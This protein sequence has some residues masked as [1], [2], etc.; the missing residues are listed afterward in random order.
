MSS[1]NN[2]FLNILGRVQ[3]AKRPRP[4]ESKLV[5]IIAVS[6]KQE[7][8]KMQDWINFCKDQGISAVF[9]ENYLQEYEKKAPVLSGDFETH[10]IGVL[11]SNKVRKSIELFEVIQTVHS[12]KLASLINTEALKQN[13]QQ[14]IFLQVN[15]SEDSKKSGFLIPDLICFIEDRLNNYHSI[16]L[17]GLMTITEFYSDNNLTKSDF[18][19]LA[20]LR[21]E[22]RSMFPEKCHSLKL[23]MGMSADFELAIEEGSDYVR[24]GTALFG[25][26]S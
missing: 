19:K 20:E 13:K 8:N 11:Q 26:R 3:T 24:I 23:S 9:G 21:E 22:L 16:S 12:D 1:N 17:E 25:E 15:I 4:T 18:K 6:K 7:A 5:Q 14:R 2:Q 10:F